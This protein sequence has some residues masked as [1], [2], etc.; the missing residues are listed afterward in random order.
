MSSV[1]KGIVPHSF[2]KLT[3]PFS[4]ISL[5]QYGYFDV[6]TLSHPFCTT[7]N[8]QL[9]FY[10]PLCYNSRTHCLLLQ[11]LC[12]TSAILAGAHSYFVISSFKC[13]GK[14]SCHDLIPNPRIYAAEPRQPRRKSTYTNHACLHI[15]L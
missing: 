2:H 15:Y 12:T 4:S 7:L 9:S 1:R 3:V 14:D 6:G 11:Y 8:L 10:R 13:E 5:P